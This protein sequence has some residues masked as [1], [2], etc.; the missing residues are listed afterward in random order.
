M[1]VDFTGFTLFLKDNF[2]GDNVPAYV[3]I[4]VLSYSSYP[5]LEA[6]FRMHSSNWIN[7]NT[8][9]LEYFGGVPAFV[10]PDNAKVAVTENKDWLDP[11]IQQA[12]LEWAAYY[13]TVIL[14]VNVK[15]V[16]HCA[17]RYSQAEVDYYLQAPKAFLKALQDNLSGEELVGLILAAEY[18]DLNREDI[19][20]GTYLEYAIEFARSQEYCLRLLEAGAD[21]ANMHSIESETMFHTVIRKGLLTMPMFK[22]FVSN[23]SDF[24][25]GYFTNVL[26]YFVR[27]EQPG[28]FQEDEKEMVKMLIGK[29]LKVE[30]S[31]SESG[32]TTSQVAERWKPYLVGVLQRRDDL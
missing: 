2:T 16:F 29:G 25:D 27:Y 21:P 19:F 32:E 14:P 28:I 15:E 3:F 13:G 1:Q 6:M 24:L 23:D 26:W 8:H 18:K 31:D 5:Y 30:D 11:E 9:V 4:A 17:D 7:A 22:V 10:T 12:Y 20:G